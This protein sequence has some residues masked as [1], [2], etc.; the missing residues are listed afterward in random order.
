MKTVRKIVLIAGPK[1]HGPEDNGIHDYPWDAKLLKVMLDNSNVADQVWVQ[2]CLDGWPADPSVLEDADAI[3]IESDGRDGHIGREALHLETEARVETVDKLVRRGCGIAVV[4]FSV[5]SA[6][7]V[8]RQVFDWYGGYFDWGTDQERKWYSAIKT[9]EADVQLASTG[10]PILS[11]VR[12]FR[13]KEEFYYN[14]RFDPS[15]KALTPLWTVPALGGREPDGNIVAW[16]HERKDGGR[17]FGTSCGHFHE[18]FRL[19]DYRTFFLNAMAWTA[20]LDVPD[21]GVRASFY[22]RDAVSLALAGTQGAERAVVKPGKTAI[23]VLLMAG[24][25]AHQWHNWQK[26]TPRIKELLE[27][28]SRIRVDVTQQAE[29][30]AKLDHARYGVLVLNYCNW[31]DP[32]PL[33]DAAK[34]GLTNWLNTGGGVLVVHFANGAFHFSLPDAGASDWPE[35]R[36]IVRRVWNHDATRGRASRHD[37]YGRFTVAVTKVNHPIT[38]G[39]NPFEVED[40][41]YFDQDGDEPIE[42]II[43]ARS[44]KTGKDEPM[45]W[46]YPYGRGRVFQTMLGHTEKTYD[47]WEAGEMLR[48]AA[49]WL[50][51][52]EVRDSRSAAHVNT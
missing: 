24:N 25:D 36:R 33:S 30:L 7:Q 47:A 42:P 37:S 19:D 16:A 39:L 22:D 10:H 9:L 29:D 21:E 1:S 50:A 14:L 12:P 45:A 8:E 11:G 52:R 27:Q 38:R 34:R 46:A 3:V 35:Y 26:T 15:D 40:E 31:K 32:A 20:G 41:L 4:H 28:D 48:R 51:G 43:T 49:A 18:N 13:M 17:G 23:N 5:F 44:A 6:H 2:C